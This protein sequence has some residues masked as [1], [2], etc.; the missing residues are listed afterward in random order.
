MNFR[1]HTYKRRQELTARWYLDEMVF[2]EIGPNNICTGHAYNIHFNSVRNTQNVLGLVLNEVKNNLGN[3]IT[4]HPAN[5]E[6]LYARV[7][8]LTNQVYGAGDMVTY[9]VALH[10][11]CNIYPKVLPQDYVYLTSPKVKKAA[12]VLVPTIRTT[13]KKLPTSVFNK[14]FK[15]Y[16]SIDIEDALCI[17]SKDITKNNRFD[18]K[19]FL[20]KNIK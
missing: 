20:T 14:W 15:E 17:F 6:D 1:E 12:K 9:D 13:D 19:W 11:G 18:T 8:K 10:I 7:K 16:H 4:P 5:F 3:I 2:G